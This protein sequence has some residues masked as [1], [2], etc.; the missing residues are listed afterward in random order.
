[1]QPARQTSEYR[2]SS[3]LKPKTLAMYLESEGKCETRVCSD[4]PVVTHWKACKR[5]DR[6]QLLTNALSGITPAVCACQADE[7]LRIQISALTQKEKKSFS[8]SVKPQLGIR[9][10]T[11]EGFV[12]VSPNAIHFSE[13]CAGAKSRF[14]LPSRPPSSPDNNQMWQRTSK[15][16]LLETTDSPR[17]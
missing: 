10:K 15:P 14:T 4:S 6:V 17:T 11:R 5:L 7:C 12:P 9:F 1:M 8:H 13:S 16:P 3:F 2:F